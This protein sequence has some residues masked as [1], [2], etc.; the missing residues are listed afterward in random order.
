MTHPLR[1]DAAFLPLAAEIL[2]R[3]APWFT[4]P[5]P[6]AYTA[7]FCEA[8]TQAG[9]RVCL[10]RETMRADPYAGGATERCELTFEHA[11]GWIR[12]QLE[13][14]AWVGLELHVVSHRETEMKKAAEPCIRTFLAA[15]ERIAP[16]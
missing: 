4:V 11:E 6:E 8:R 1:D 13:T 16:T 3:I 2:G 7:P 14:I 10:R 5:T 15:F 9:L 12:I